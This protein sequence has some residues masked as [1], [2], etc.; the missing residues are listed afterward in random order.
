[1]QEQL[2]KTRIA[3]NTLLLYFRLLLT[4]VV[5][6]YTSRVILDKLG[7]EDYGIYNVVGGIVAMM[8]FLNSAMVAASQRF[9]SYEIGTGN[10]K[11]LKKIFQTSVLIHV[12]IAVFILVLSE[13]IGLWLVN[14]YLNIAPDRMVA[15]NYVYQSAIGIFI[16]TILTVPFNSCVIAHERMNMFAYTSVL[17]YFLK[18]GICYLLGVSIFDKLITYGVLLLTVAIIVSITYIVYCRRNFIES[19][20]TPSY[21]KEIFTE[22]FFFAGWNLFGNLGSSFKDQIINVILNVFCG[23]RINAARGIA[24]QVNGIINTLASNIAM[25]INPQITKQY[26]AGNIV[27]SKTLVFACARYS[28]FLL[29]VIAVPFI[30]NI[31]Q[32]LGL[33]L[34]EVPEYTSQFLIISIIVS[35]I[36]TLTGSISTAIQATGNVKVFQVGVSLIML[37]EIPITY[38]LLRFGCNAVI[39]VTPTLFTN[40]LAL[41]FRYKLIS[42]Y[43]NVYGWMEYIV[44]TILRSLLVFILSFLLSLFLRNNLPQNIT[45]TIVS[46]LQSGIT[47]I[48][49]VYL[50]GIS[51][52][53]KDLVNI[54]II[55]KLK[56]IHH[57]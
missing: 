38:M 34:V 16:V 27:Q 56:K 54:F 45:G 18:L 33:W 15:A 13:T 7:V 51:S 19:R 44:N 5:G 28:F 20:S 30:L 4:V 21:D 57:D 42:K 11:R 1:M 49:M 29:S 50:I 26:A 8:S 43:I 17:E 37:F 36:Y 9:L 24:I 2:N 55:S 46:L 41:I 3:K 53:E 31:D 52:K 12:I 6:L 14:N 32:L 39:A 25:A 47:V 35:L 48:G 22:M 40:S 10:T 23:T